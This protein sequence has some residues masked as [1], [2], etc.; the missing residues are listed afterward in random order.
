METDEREL[1]NKHRKLKAE[2]M[3][4]KTLLENLRKMRDTTDPDLFNSTE[5]QHREKLAQ[6]EP[7][8]KKLGE[9]IKSRIE[10]LGPDL[11]ISQD[12]IEKLKGLLDQEAKLYKNGAILK[13]DYDT[14]VDPLKYQLKQA[15]ANYRTIKSEVEFL[16]SANTPTKPPVFGHPGSQH[17]GVKVKE[18]P[19]R[20]LLY[21]FLIGLLI[22]LAVILGLPLLGIAFWTAKILIIPAVIIFVAIIIIALFGKGFSFLKKKW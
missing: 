11:K 19:P 17:G 20:G 14:R 1:V 8:M 12:K 7:E 6:I 21:Y 15:Q 5:C 13:E 18:T 3:Q 4:T 10:Q 22:I 16:K 2:L 9:V